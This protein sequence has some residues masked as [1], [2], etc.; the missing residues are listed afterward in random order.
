MFGM[1]MTLN[2]SKVKKVLS[3]PYVIVTAVCL[4][5]SAMPLAAYHSN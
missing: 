3:K 2:F 5:F 4:Q 1:G